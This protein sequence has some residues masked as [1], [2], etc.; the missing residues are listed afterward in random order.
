MS[1]KEAASPA[2]GNAL[3]GFL[4][5]LIFVEVTS[6]FV[7]GFY[8]PLLP[9]LAK[10]VGV[11]SEA[12]N[13]FQTAQAI[14]AAV[15]VPL[16]SRLGDLYGPRR[17]LR[18]A[19]F[20]VLVGTILIA[21]VPSYPVVLIGRVL[22]GPLG[23][24]LPL[25]IAIVYARTAGETATRSISILS[26]SLMGGIVLGTIVAGIADSISPNLVITLLVPVIMVAISLY[27]VVFRLPD[28]V[29]EAV[30]SIDWAGFAGLA[31]MMVSLIVAL[32]YLG[33]SHA[34]LSGVM[35]AV[36]VAIGALWF[37]WEKRV[38][39]P[40][41]DLSLVLSPGLGVFYIVGFL[42]G[43][44]MI[45][46]PPAL[47]DFLAHDPSIYGY[48][49]MAGTTLIA[50]MITVM[51]LLATAGAFASS[52]ISKRF[53]MRRT[54]IAAAGVGAV[55]QLSLAVFHTFLPAFWIGGALTG[56][57]LGVLVGALP[58]LV[59]QSAPRDKTGIATGLYNA[60]V[61][62]GGAVGGA[63]FRLA[64]VAFRE[65]P[66]FF[67][68]AHIVHVEGYMTIWVISGATF[69]L[70]ALLLIRVKMPDAVVEE[71]E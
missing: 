61:A 11:S 15:S 5:F 46:A 4:G 30:A 28:S 47:A 59:A 8:S 55:G 32:A 1:K 29:A 37:W 25:A 45:D 64:L 67:D 13:W 34:V 39:N 12:M 48:G 3:K 50:E 35:F 33:P 70:I 19:V 9:E 40:A 23:V 51:L 52:F 20:A 44:V 18:G 6:G 36:T 63:L 56:A 7:Q 68:G 43:I 21:V 58:A 41:V 60:L 71:T 14:A 42:L 62:M 49:F 10:H 2:A 38:S 53:G 54:L 66:D 57:G 26:A 27:A 17:I 69:V 24:W 31:A 65:K 22:I 16:L